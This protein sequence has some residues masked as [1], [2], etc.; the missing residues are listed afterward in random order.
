VHG[1]LRQLANEVQA[2]SARATE[3]CRAVEREAADAL[4]RMHQVRGP[5]AARLDAIP[6]VP[7]AF[8]AG[9]ETPR[10]L[11]R[12]REMIHDAARKSERLSAA[13]E[14]VP[15][16]TPWRG[17]PQRRVPDSGCSKPTTP[18]I[19]PTIRTHL[20]RRARSDHE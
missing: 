8:D 13:G 18:S 10:L 19:P 9:D 3:L 2:A 20:R 17:R 6:P 16:R 1:E 5:V 12:M 4:A 15:R 11:E 7:S 14:R